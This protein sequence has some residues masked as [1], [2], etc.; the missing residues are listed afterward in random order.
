MLKYVFVALFASLITSVGLASAEYQ[1]RAEAVADN[2]YTLVGPLGQRSADNDGLN[3]NYA[4]V[5]TAQGVILI[6]SGASR[7]GAEKLATAI[8]AVTPQPVRWVINT[9]SQDHRW[10]GH[11]YF[12]QHGAQ[13]ALALV[14]AEVVHPEPVHLFLHLVRGIQGAQQVAGGGLALQAVEFLLIG[15][16]GDLLVLVERNRIGVTAPLLQLLHQ[17]DQRCFADRHGVDLALLFVWQRQRVRVQLRLQKLWPTLLLELGHG[18]AAGTP[19]QAVEQRVG[20][21]G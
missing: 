9:G 18:A 19:A 15:L 12:A 3:A 5:I 13:I 20:V 14:H 11:D 1:P 6:D 21:A 4:F 17:L 8:R 2:V 16:T 10:L 7:L